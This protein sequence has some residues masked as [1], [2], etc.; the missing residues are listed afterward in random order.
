[1]IH[2]LQ[3]P[4]DARYLF[5]WGDEIKEVEKHLNKIPQYMFLP[6]FAGIPKPEVFLNR[7]KTKDGRTIFWCFSGLWKEIIDFLDKK[8][9]KHD[10]IPRTFIRTGFNLTLEAFTDVITGWGLNINPRDYQVRAAW[11]ILHYRQSLSQLATRA[12]KT[13]IAYIIFRYLL[14]NGAHNILMVVPSTQ[15]VRQ[16]VEDMKEYKEFFTSETVWADGELCS[17]SNL[18]IGTFQ[19]LVLKATPRRKGGGVNKKYDPT[20]FNKF[21]VVLIDECHTAK[22]ESIKT[23]LTQPFLKN[24]KVRFGFSGS[25]ADA[26][27][28]DSFACQSL[29]GP[30]VQDLRSKELM[31]K[32]FITPI[33]IT[34]IRIKHKLTP[35]LTKS[36]IKYGEYLCSNYRMAGGKQ[37]LLPKE[38]RDF[39]IRHE[40]VL[41]EAIREMKAL[42]DDDEYRECL[43]DMC[44]AKG[45]DLLMLEQMI[46]FHDQK[47]LE[48]MD[49]ILMGIT[50]NTIVFA[51]HTE[52]LSFLAQHFRSIFPGRNVYQISGSTTPKNRDKIIT[53]LQND[54][55]AI[56]VASYGCVGTGVTF[57]N[58][59][60]GILA[61]SFRS[62]IVNL[63]SAGRGLCLAPGKDKFHLYDIIDCLPTQRLE[64]QG[65]SKVKLFRQ[66]GFDIKVQTVEA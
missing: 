59:D 38:Q 25:L 13:L 15:L 52:Y 45:S 62:K 64:V 44:K 12:G 16:G 1:M 32:G 63:Q 66:Q 33:E 49:D 57:R 21:D 2:F 27:T 11:V 35:S 65:I 54:T 29:L 8:G 36:Y 60:Y 4:G 56:L 14:E 7:F 55:G 30:M 5:L 41:P 18:T 26:G 10:D 23:I 31:D 51:H 53:A 46:I 34:Q 37:V 48:V 39:T 9:I 43:V 28:I 61:Q 47:R 19:S 24:V 3:N 40:K 17:S 50:K 58:V 6:S 22:C 20:F 42:Y